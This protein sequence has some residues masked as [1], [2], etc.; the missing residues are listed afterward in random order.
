MRICMF[1]MTIIFY[2]GHDYSVITPDT[3]NSRMDKQVIT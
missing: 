2:L 1:T 3:F